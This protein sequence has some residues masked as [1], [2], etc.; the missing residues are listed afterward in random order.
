MC[1]CVCVC[2]W[3]Y[4]CVRVCVRVRA[5]VHV[6]LHAC[7]RVC[8]WY[9]K[10]D[11]TNVKSLSGRKKCSKKWNFMHLWKKQLTESVK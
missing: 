10:V 11:R 5:C 4:T 1:V 2:V 7:V 8:V 6:C 3:V 9:V